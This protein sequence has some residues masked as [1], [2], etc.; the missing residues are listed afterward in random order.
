MTEKKLEEEYFVA[1]DNYMKLKF[2]CLEKRFYWNTA[3]CIWLHVVY[4]CFHATMPGVVAGQRLCGLQSLRFLIIWYFGE[5]M[6]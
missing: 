3:T 1:P 2:P 6:C 4:G 5:K